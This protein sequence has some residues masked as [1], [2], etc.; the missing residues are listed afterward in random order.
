MG[1]PCNKITQRI[2]IDPPKY[3]KYQSIEATILTNE[4]EKKSES[5]F[6]KIDLEYKIS[7]YIIDYKE[8][9]FDKDC[10]QNNEL[11]NEYILIKSE[12]I[13]KVLDSFPED[14]EEENKTVGELSKS[15]GIISRNSQ[16]FAQTIYDLLNISFKHYKGNLN[17][18]NNQEKHIQLSGWVKK[19]LNLNFY[20]DFC[21][22]KN[23]Y[24]NENNEFLKNCLLK[25]TKF[26]TQ[27]LLSYNKIE[28][29]YTEE[30]VE[31]NKNEMEDINEIK[32]N[33][34]LVNFTVLPGLYCNGAYLDN[35]K[36]QVFTYTQDTFHFIDKVF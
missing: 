19:S 32:G 2:P 20:E 24:K 16:N 9:I 3:E 12:I 14:E 35:A 29:K 31:F 4:S 21:K 1:N 13:Q 26:Y 15:I 30:N 28:F 17:N 11:K 18:L 34:K 25:L 6:N 5:E 10:Y 27:C 22:L 23:E 8:K 36:I 7:N 33:K